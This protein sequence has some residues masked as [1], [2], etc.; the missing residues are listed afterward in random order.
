MRL[1]ILQAPAEGE[2]RGLDI[3]LVH[4]SYSAAWVWEE[5]FMPALAGQGY[6][7]HAL[8]LRG[9]GGSET[10]KPLNTVSLED[11]VEDVKKAVAEIGRPLVIV[12]HSL[13]GAVVQGAI[14]SGLSVV[15]TALISSVPPSGMLMATQRMFW[16]RPRL[17]FELS[18]MMYAGIDSADPEV[19]R[20]GLFDNRVSADTFGSLAT[21]FCDESPLAIME[22]MGIRSFG[23]PPS[24]AGPVL[25]M[26]GSRDWFISEMDL[27]QTARWYGTAPVIL[28][29]MSHAV[30]L[31][32]D[33]ER[34]VKVLCEWL[35]PL[36]HD[37]F[38]P[39]PSEA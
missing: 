5:K 32:P 23:A 34:A 13:G 19:L 11:Y 39:Y 6:D 37:R 18:K 14:A 12:G 36:D 4:G 26:G 25:V 8:S 29:G 7:V 22:L 10:A 31:D 30:M 17:W 16:R 21:R 1:E 3:L 28:D 38:G 20:D 15:G 9:H 2:P 24:Q 33:G 27:W 35:E